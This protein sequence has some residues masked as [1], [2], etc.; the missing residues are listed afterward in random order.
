MSSGIESSRYLIIGWRLPAFLAARIANWNCGDAVAMLAADAV[1]QFGGHR[2]TAGNAL[3]HQGL[4]LFCFFARH[5]RT[6]VKGLGVKGL[7]PPPQYPA[8]LYSSA[9][10]TTVTVVST[11]L[12]RLMATTCSPNDLIGS[13]RRIR[14]RSMAKPRAVSWRSMS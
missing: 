8:R 3:R 1:D 11:P 13:S 2:L 14:R 4:V 10:T 12:P 7:V 6:G 5:A 9:S